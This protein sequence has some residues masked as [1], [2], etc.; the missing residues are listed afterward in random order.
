VIRNSAWKIAILMDLTHFVIGNLL[1]IYFTRTQGTDSTIESILGMLFL[2]YTFI[3]GIAEFAGWDSAALILDFAALL[4][5]LAIFYPIGA[6][7]EKK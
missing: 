2:P 6:L 4:F 3:A 7:L 5:M 1:G